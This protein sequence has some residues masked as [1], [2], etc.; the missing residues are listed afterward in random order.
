MSERFPKQPNSELARK[1][2]ERFASSP[3]MFAEYEDRGV[4]ETNNLG[5]RMLVLDA[6]PESELW[7]YNSYLLTPEIIE[8]LERVKSREPELW[9]ESVAAYAE[10]TELSSE[11]FAALQNLGG[12]DPQ[13]KSKAEQ[14]KDAE[15]HDAQLRTKIFETIEQESITEEEAIALCR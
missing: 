3:E 8:R 1:I 13:T 12:N 10:R 6:G 15:W 14:A 7:E 5:L 9:Q 4:I 2:T 11:Y